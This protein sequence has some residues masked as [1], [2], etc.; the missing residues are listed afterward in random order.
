M[1]ACV[2]CIYVVDAIDTPTPTTPTK[3]S[4]EQ[5]PI[6]H[7]P[8]AST[9][10]TKP[11]RCWVATINIRAGDGAAG[12]NLQAVAKEGDEKQLDIICC[13]ETK[14]TSNRHVTSMGSFNIIAS[15]LSTRN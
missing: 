11:C 5:G 2:G 4:P 10:S 9:S 3:P 7:E 15:K 12:H 8:T 13:Q 6:Q 14:I 1:Q